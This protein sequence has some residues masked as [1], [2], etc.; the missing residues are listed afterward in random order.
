[1]DYKILKVKSINQVADIFNS[2]FKSK[3][4]EIVTI[5]KSLIKLNPY[6]RP[7]AY[8]CLRNKVFDPYRDKQVEKILDEM[9]GNK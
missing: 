3:G 1:M 9:K 7:T 5:W 8:E 4:R 6:Y 2:K